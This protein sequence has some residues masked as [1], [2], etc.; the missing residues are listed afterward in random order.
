MSGLSHNTLQ[1]GLRNTRESLS[2]PVESVV[3]PGA[4]N[5]YL[6]SVSLKTMMSLQPITKGVFNL[7]AFDVE[8]A[9]RAEASIDAFI[10]SRSRSQE[11][12]NREEAAWAEST[13]RFNERRRER[14]RLL[15]REY[16]LRRAEGLERTAAELAASHRSKAEA[17]SEGGYEP[18]EAPGPEE[19]GEGVAAVS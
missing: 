3:L 14:N 13:R 18:D 5:F 16:H 19:E 1:T 2:R 7:D 12:A 9:E 17:L 4:R 6:P 15:W 10:L 11:E 8:A